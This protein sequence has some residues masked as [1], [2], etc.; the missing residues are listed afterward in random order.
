[1]NL[2]F[3]RLTPRRLRLHGT[4]KWYENT[5]DSVY[6]ARFHSPKVLLDTIYDKII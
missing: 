2:L 5:A 4:N 6:I 3:N 1:M